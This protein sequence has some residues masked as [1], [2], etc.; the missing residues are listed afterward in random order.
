[1]C[2]KCHPLL[3]CNKIIW[4]TEAVSWWSLLLCST[5][6]QLQGKPSSF[7]RQCIEQINIYPRVQCVY[8]YIALLAS[9]ASLADVVGFFALYPFKYI[10]YIF[11]SNW[12]PFCVTFMQLLIFLRLKW[13]CKTCNTIHNLLFSARG[14]AGSCGYF[15]LSCEKLWMNCRLQA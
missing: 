8:I 15:F 6:T 12:I 3:R 2:S 10:L 1:M 11:E 13:V 4:S 5:W 9:D 7:L 14:F